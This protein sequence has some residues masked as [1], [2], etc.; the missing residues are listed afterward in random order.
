M[1]TDL[2]LQDFAAFSDFRWSGHGQIN[3]VVGENDTGK[4][5]LLKVLYAIAKTVETQAA[6][7]AGDAEEASEPG[8]FSS[9][10]SVDVPASTF[11][12]ADKERGA[13]SSY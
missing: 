11:G 13:G 12:G 2:H 8:A 9:K 4:S 3:V 10:A 1:F 7:R 6:R 5:H